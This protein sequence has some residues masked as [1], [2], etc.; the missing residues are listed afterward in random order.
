MSMDLLF[1]Y[2]AA[3]RF[4]DETTFIFVIYLLEDHSKMFVFIK[5]LPK[6]FF[7]H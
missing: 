4:P 6:C 3:H 5:A 7:Q 2:G 1:C